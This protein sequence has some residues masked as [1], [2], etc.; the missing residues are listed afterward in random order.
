MRKIFSVVAFIL[1]ST[2]YSFGQEAIVP[3]FNY[4]YSEYVQKLESGETKIDYKDFRFS[5]V[6]SKQFM[7][8][9]SNHQS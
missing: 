9:L 2:I 3:D 1:S 5:F 4:K 7:Q 6:E 8:H